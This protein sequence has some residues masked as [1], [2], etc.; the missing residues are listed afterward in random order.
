MPTAI[1]FPGQGSQTDAMRELVER[2]E[3]EL[4]EIAL[5]EVGADPFALAGEGT[6][7][8]QP[9]ILCASLASWA[10]R[11]PPRGGASSR[12]TRSGSSARWPRP[13]RSISPTRCGWPRCAGG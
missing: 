1:L 13:A 7:Y 3:P 12:A 9:A 4:A 11:R 6:A 2:H 10:R 5:A 8:A